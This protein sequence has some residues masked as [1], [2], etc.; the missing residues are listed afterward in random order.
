MDGLN[1]MT[2]NGVRSHPT[3]RRLDHWQGRV[4]QNGPAWN[5]YCGDAAKKTR[6]LNA[7]RYACAMTS[8]PYF[9]QRDYEVAGQIGL[10]LT[11]DAYVTAI[12]DAMEEVRRVLHPKGVLF[13]NLGDTYYSGKGQPHGNDRKHN[14]RRLKML[15]LVDASGLGK[16]KKTLLGMPWR[17]A[18]AMIDRGWILRAP[19][20]WRRENAI[21]EASVSD[22]P[23]RTFEHVFLFSKSRSYNFSRA[24]LKQA[25][26]EDVWTIESPS[27]AGR[28]HP[29]VFPQ[30]LVRRCLAIG[31]P[32]LGPVLDPFAGSAT[33]LRTALAMGAD[34]DGIEL[35]RTYCRAA[36]AELKRLS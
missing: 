5:L 3:G 14:G 18:L 9:W 24:A 34:A 2:L 28:V 26:E 36:A 16:P 21:P 25:G 33:V 22:R 15:R 11:V 4:G 23:W 7:D 19:I 29:A 6:E 10:E 1:G 31:N 30:E 35:N 32:D 8:P 12:C 27:R 20:I 17:I 13:L